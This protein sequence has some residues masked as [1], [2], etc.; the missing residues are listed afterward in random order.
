MPRPA[1]GPRLYAQPERRN[2]KT[3]EI[4]EHAV[5]VIRDG[6]I[7]RSTGIGVGSGRT[8]PDE[9]FD[10]L[11]EYIKGRREPSREKQR[12]AASVAVADVIAIY[13]KD[14]T[15]TQARPK[16]VAGRAKRLLA[17]WGDKTLDQVTGPVCREYVETRGNSGASRRELEDLRAAIVHHRK[18]GLCREVVEVVLPEKG[19]PRERW[20]TRSE[21]ARLIL[22]AWKYRE[23]QKGKPSKRRSRRHVARFIL[24]AAYTGTRAGAVCGAALEPTEG[25]GWINLETGVF[26]RRPQGERETKKRKAPVRLPERLL[27]H[28][29]RWKRLNICKNYAVEWLGR[30]V[31]DVD[32]AFR[33]TVNDVKLKGNVTP[34]TL[35]HTAITWAMQ[36]GMSKEDAAG[37]FSTTVETI[38]RHY[39]HHHPDFQKEAAEK[40]GQRPRQKPDRNAGNK[41]EQTATEVT[42][43]VNIAEAC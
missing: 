10:A 24:V 11:S 6:R 42:N 16:E 17:F 22:S 5:W 1:K 35:K 15:E 23:M 21:A 28:L 29:R 2:T 20:L 31:L 4:I 26:Y 33:N 19:L 32:K 40:M 7:K 38:E 43:V 30:P 12:T 41:R 27:V 9:A 3:G 36:N 39:W 13:L 34:H 18:E 14:K 25:K 37:F 8:P